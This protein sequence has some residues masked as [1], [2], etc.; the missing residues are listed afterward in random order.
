MRE[1]SF[2]YREHRLRTTLMLADADAERERCAQED[3]ALTRM[4]D[5]L[6]VFSIPLERKIGKT[7]IWVHQGGKE[8]NGAIYKKDGCGR[9]RSCFSP[10]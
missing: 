7:K 9:T 5:L 8:E 4:L 1:Y 3:A 2:R 10:V 6:E